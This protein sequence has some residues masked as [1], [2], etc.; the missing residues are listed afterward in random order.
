MGEA[1][2]SETVVWVV[3]GW[4]SHD[5]VELSGH[6]VAVWGNLILSLLSEFH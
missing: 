4:Q 1:L 3:L 2:L 5:L 6:L